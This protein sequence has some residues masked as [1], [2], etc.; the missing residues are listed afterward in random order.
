MKRRYS[1]FF[2]TDLQILLT[3]LGVD[4]LIITGA[5]T[6]VCV[7]ATATDA[8]QYGYF[9]YVP[10]DCVAGT[11]PLQHEAA[12]EHIRYILGKVITLSDITGEK[13]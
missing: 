2:Q 13:A 11:S 12:L 6:D 8:Q 10:K 5:A 7:R 9:V 3:S 1:G 4:T